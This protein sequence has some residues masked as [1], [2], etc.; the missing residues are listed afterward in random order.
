LQEFLFGDEPS[1]LDLVVFSH[2]AP[3]SQIRIDQ[4]FFVDD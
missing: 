2:M 4:D 1:L 3:V